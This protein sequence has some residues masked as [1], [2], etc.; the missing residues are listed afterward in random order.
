MGDHLLRITW[1]DEENLAD[2]GPE[3]G[4]FGRTC[5]GCTDREVAVRLLWVELNRGHQKIA[6][7]LEGEEYRTGFDFLSDT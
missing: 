7:V 5:G 3:G 6:G 1:E 2:V 4:P